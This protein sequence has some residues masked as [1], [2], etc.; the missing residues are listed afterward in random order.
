M[1]KEDIAKKICK[2]Y[3]IRWDENQSVSHVEGQ[4][5]S[6]GTVCMAFLDKYNFK[7]ENEK[8]RQ[9]IASDNK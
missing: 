1:D 5:V 2:K 3:R 4:Q 7:R 6:S 9:I 8:T